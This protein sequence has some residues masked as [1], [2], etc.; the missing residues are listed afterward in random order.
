MGTIFPRYCSSKVGIYELKF[1]FTE[2]SKTFMSGGWFWLAI[3]LH[4]NQ[5]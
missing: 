4:G 2:N 3:T 1:K 5:N